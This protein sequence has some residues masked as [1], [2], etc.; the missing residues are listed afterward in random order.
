MVTPSGATTSGVRRAAGD[1]YRVGAQRVAA[2][3]LNT[4]GALPVAHYLAF[5]SVFHNLA[6]QRAQ[7]LRQMWQADRAFAR[8]EN[9]ILRYRL[10]VYLR[11]RLR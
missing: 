11:I 6:A 2:R 5:S 3:Q 8:V 9:R 4:A 7:L 1:Q 10:A